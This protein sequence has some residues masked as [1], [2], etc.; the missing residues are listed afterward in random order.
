MGI[1]GRTGSSSFAWL[2]TWMRGG[3]M[4]SRA[5]VLGGRTL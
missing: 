1:W 4:R 5:R 2:L 3:V